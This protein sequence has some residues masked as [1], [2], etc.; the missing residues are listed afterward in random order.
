MKTV[1]RYSKEPA[2]SYRY[3]YKFIKLLSAAYPHWI[4]WN[5]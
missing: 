4:I 1:L 2:S 5:E 3:I